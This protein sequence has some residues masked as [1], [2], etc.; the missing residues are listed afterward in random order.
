MAQTHQCMAN[1]P[2]AGVHSSQ[3]HPQCS[4]LLFMCRPASLKHRVGRVL[5]KSQRTRSCIVICRV[6]CYLQYSKQSSTR[7][8]ILVLCNSPC[9]ACLR[10]I[11]LDSASCTREPA[12]IVTCCR[13]RANFDSPLVRIAQSLA[14]PT[15]TS[16][17]AITAV[18]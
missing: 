8:A 17:D 9:S 2:A 7:S 16:L 14:G 13:G 4:R 11:Q 10:R 3:H 12:D 1:G 18:S 15:C 6:C 5:H